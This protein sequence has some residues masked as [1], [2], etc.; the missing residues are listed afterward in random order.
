MLLSKVR[1][2]SC[3]VSTYLPK[4]RTMA[5]TSIEVWIHIPFTSEN[6]STMWCRLTHQDGFRARLPSIR[7]TRKVFT[8]TQTSPL[9]G[10]L[11]YV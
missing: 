2:T 7:R 4:I 8:S 5:V 11:V 9:K 10:L 1:S 6:W 3:A